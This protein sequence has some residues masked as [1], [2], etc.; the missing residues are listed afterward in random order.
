MTFADIGYAGAAQVYD[1][2]TNAVMGTFN[3]QYTALV[4]LH[5]TAFLRVADM[6]P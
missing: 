1:I 4:P 5:G 2:W 6:S 3:T